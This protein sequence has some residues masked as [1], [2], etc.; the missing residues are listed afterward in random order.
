MP[1]AAPRSPSRHEGNPAFNPLNH[2]SDAVDPNI[3][4]VPPHDPYSLLNPGMEI[5]EDDIKRLVG[6]GQQWV[7]VSRSMSPATAFPA[8]AVAYAR[9]EAPENFLVAPREKIV[10]P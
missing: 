7:P 5:M 4:A 1:T 6:E 10:A 9:V 3:L 2:N 8:A